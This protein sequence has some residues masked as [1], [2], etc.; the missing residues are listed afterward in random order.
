MIERFVPSFNSDARTLGIT[1]PRVCPRI[2]EF[3]PIVIA[4]L[5]TAPNIKLAQDTTNVR[6]DSVQC[7]NQLGRDLS[8]RKT[9]V[10]ERKYLLLTV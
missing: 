7:H 3:G 1:Y 5:P 8:I 10:N 2:S 6:L 4:C 9:L